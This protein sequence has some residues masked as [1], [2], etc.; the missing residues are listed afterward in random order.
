MIILDSSFIISSQIENDQN[1]QIASSLMEDIYNKRY[2]TPIISD[3]IF[4]ETVTVLFTK[5]K[6][7]NKTIKICEIIKK[8]KMRKVDREIFDNAWQI[9]KEQKNT[10]LSF[11]DCTILAIMRNEGISNIATFDKDFKKIDGINVIQN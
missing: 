10:K 6:D 7:L 1:H 2:G 4:N 9:F 3:Y 11:T 5:L 8:Q